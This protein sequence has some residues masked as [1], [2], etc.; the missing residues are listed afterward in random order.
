MYS[1]PIERPLPPHRCAV[2]TPLDSITSFYQPRSQVGPNLCMTLQVLKNKLL[3]FAYM[4]RLIKYR[5]FKPPPIEELE[6]KL[7][8]MTVF[9][10]PGN[11]L[12]SMLCPP[13]I[14]KTENS[15]FEINSAN[16]WII[17]V[18]SEYLLMTYTFPQ[19]R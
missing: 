16:P 19:H 17:P 6:S 1:F 14:L 9:I 18:L 13:C 12:V 5:I 15:N 7:I 3:T 8:S 2:L 11:I 10:H 4:F